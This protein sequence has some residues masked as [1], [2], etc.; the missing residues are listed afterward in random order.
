MSTQH[1]F[2]KT[3]NKK[4]RYRVQRA[5]WLCKPSAWTVLCII[6]I[7]PQLSSAGCPQMDPPLLCQVKTTDPLCFAQVGTHALSRI[8]LGAEGGT[9]GQGGK[10]IACAVRREP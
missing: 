5:G 6:I 3:V 9:G 4:V 8:C 2:S 7:D 1:T 10:S